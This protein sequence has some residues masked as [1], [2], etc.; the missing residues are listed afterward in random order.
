MANGDAAAAAGIATVPDTRDA[1]MGY[2]DLNRILDLL[3]TR[4]F[5]SAQI[6]DGSVRDVELAANAVTTAKIADGAI[7]RAKFGPKALSTWDVF[8]ADNVT[9]LQNFL[10]NEQQRLNGIIADAVRQGAGDI[11]TGGGRFNSIGSRNF[12][13]SVNY[14]SAYMDGNNWLGITP[15]AM[16]F[17]QDIEHAAY[18]LDDALRLASCVATYR[19]RDRVNGVRARG[20]DGAPSPLA[21][22]WEVEPDPDAP[23]EVGVIAEWLIE[24]GFEEFVVFN[25]AGETQS[26]NYER[27]VLIVAGGLAELAGYFLEMRAELSA[28]RADL[29]RLLQKG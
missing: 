19:L 6:A 20:Y 1:K 29:D 23:G 4:I 13:V 2:D 18:S 11:H 5:G 10:G 27:L 8:L 7:T 17:K 16:R 28:I 26:V 22:E 25:D 12:P 15:S 21:P 24:N 3:V 9:V 14:A